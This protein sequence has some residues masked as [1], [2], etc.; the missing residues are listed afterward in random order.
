MSNFKTS[1]DMQLDLQ[2]EWLMDLNKYAGHN[3]LFPNLKKKTYF[4]AADFSDLNE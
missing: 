3:P 1:I 4:S 2:G